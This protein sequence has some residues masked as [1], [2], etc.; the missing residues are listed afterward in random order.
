MVVK[1]G[2]YSGN[3]S[4]VKSDLLSKLVTTYHQKLTITAANI[5]GEIYAE[6]IVQDVWESLARGD[7][8]L[9]DIQSISH[10]LYRV[11]TN[12]SLNRSKREIR[13]LSLEQLNS[14][15]SSKLNVMKHNDP[16]ML[17]HSPE[18]IILGAQMVTAL[19]SSW[20]SLPNVQQ[21]AIE[22]RYFAG[23]SYAQIASELRMTISNTKVSLHRAKA[24]LLSSA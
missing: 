6:E 18:E 15:F 10:W 8:C 21:R 2:R 9:E 1:S 23:Y 16:T 19:V 22:L 24:K 17:E 7:V 5:V 4:Q 3:I 11:V 20:E 12:K 13:S 14:E